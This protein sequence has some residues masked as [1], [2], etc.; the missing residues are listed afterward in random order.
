MSDHGGLDPELAAELRLG[1][2]REWAEEAAE[3]ERLTELLRRRR[4]SLADV[5]RDFAHQGARVSVEAGG[6]SFS[7]VIVAAGDDYATL[8]GAGQIT[9]VRYD[10]GAWS[11]IAADQPAPGR[12]VVAT[13]SFKGRLHEHAAARARL[14]LAL[15]NG[16]TI[17]GVIE[18]AASDHLE[19]TDVDSRR[20]YVPLNRI[21]GASRSTDPH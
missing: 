11:V 14:Q 4:L 15:G 2:G 9:E 1:A 5:M 13:E 19:F 21:L 17:T 10:A 6:H 20:F 18:V 16:I 12:E 8:E 7:G 3:D